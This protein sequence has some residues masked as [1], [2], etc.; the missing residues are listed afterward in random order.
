MR[1][2]SV[3]V[4]FHVAW[5]L[6]VPPVFLFL[7]WGPQQA[8]VRVATGLL[9]LY[10]NFGVCGCLLRYNIQQDQLV[11]VG[12]TGFY[13]TPVERALPRQACHSHGAYAAWN[14]F[15]GA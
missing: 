12:Q 15:V 14:V 10:R 2:L 8:Y 13:T 1:E 4:Q 3:G 5:F 9:P 6:V 7:L 11:C